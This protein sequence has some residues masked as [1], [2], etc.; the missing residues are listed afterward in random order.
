MKFFLCSLMISWCSSLLSAPVYYEMKNCD[1]EVS[2]IFAK[3]V[4][5][6][7]NYGLNDL[8]VK[9]TSSV[10]TCHSFQIAQLF[11][12]VTAGFGEENCGVRVKFSQKDELD[13]FA[14]HAKIFGSSRQNLRWIKDQYTAADVQV[15]AEI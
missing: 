6:Q 1:D 3:A 12:D 14:K 9:A 5:E 15:C 7:V 2:R 13:L 8:Q 10:G 11:N 4:L